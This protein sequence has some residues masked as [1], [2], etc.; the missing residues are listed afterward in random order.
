[1]NRTL[2]KKRTSTAA[3]LFAAASGLGFLAPATA[4]HAAAPDPVYWSFSNNTYY[5]NQCL[6]GGKKNSQG[7]SSVFMATCTGSY[8]QKWDWRGE[9]PT[10]PSFL[11]LQNKAT[12]LCLATDYKSDDYN[13]VWASTCEWRPGMR[14]RYVFN[15]DMPNSGGELMSDFT[16]PPYGDYSELRPAA[17]GAVYNGLPDFAWN[18]TF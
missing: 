7:T 2:R 16:H 15:D 12:G 18:G 9:D 3:L 13:A 10:N 8:Y 14:F 4:A 11:E 6:T 5:P 1:M 17:S